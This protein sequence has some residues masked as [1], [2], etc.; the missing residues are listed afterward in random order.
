VRLKLVSMFVATV[1]RT[2]VHKETTVESPIQRISRPTVKALGRLVN[3]NVAGRESDFMRVAVKVFNADGPGIS[4]LR[5]VNVV[6]AT[7]IVRLL[8]VNVHHELTVVTVDYG[9]IDSVRREF[10]AG[11]LFGVMLQ[12]FQ[13]S[14]RQIGTIDKER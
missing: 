6:N 1:S 12:L 7:D 8:L 3:E 14:L 10:H 4:I 2:V 9:T 5:A 13:D 11:P